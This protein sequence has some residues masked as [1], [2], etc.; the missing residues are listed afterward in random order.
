[1]GLAFIVAGYFVTTSLT[2]MRTD[3]KTTV[4]AEVQRDKAELAA[5]H[6]EAQ[7][8]VQQELANVRIEVQKRI[9]TEFQSANITALVSNAAKE[10]TEKELTA[11][12]QSETSSQV[13]KSIREQGP[14]IQKAVEDQT[15]QAVNA[16]QP[17]IKET[18][19]A[20]TATYGSY[21]RVGQLAALAKN[22]S[23]TAFESLIE[24][25]EGHAAE[26]RIPE[27]VSLADSTVEAILYDEERD[28]KTQPSESSVNYNH[29]TPDQIQQG[30]QSHNQADRVRLLDDLPRLRPQ[31]PFPEV[32]ASPT[33]L[34]AVDLIK[35]D[36]SIR[37]IARANLL[38]NR[39]TGQ[40]FK[41]WE[42]KGMLTWWAAHQ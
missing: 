34:I 13:A 40:H 24:I 21:I 10:R 36:P 31:K 16:L 17:T 35:S 19:E 7:A 39:Q 9:D 28:L 5:F 22:D 32:A 15:K 18:V 30:L 41:W 1:M 8:T 12:I 20:Q 11:L 25:R 6:A 37:V 14:T 27:L 42:I 2:Q 26:S 33:L 4:D 3:A 38:F 29:Y 23:R